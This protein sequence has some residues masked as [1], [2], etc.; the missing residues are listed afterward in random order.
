ME[1]LNDH[2]GNPVGLRRTGYFYR[3][4]QR[5]QRMSLES[6]AHRINAEWRCIASAITAAFRIVY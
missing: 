5:I 3:L 1:V 4:Q 6:N 2:C